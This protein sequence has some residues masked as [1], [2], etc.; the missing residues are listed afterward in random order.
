MHENS[1]QTMFEHDE[2]V[3]QLENEV[4]RAEMALFI[5]TF[6]KLYMAYLIIVIAS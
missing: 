3:R 4:F 6:I 5:D 1:K 2:K